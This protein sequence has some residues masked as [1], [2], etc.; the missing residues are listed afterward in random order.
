ML[1][2]AT[3]LILY[4]NYREGSEA[5]CGKQDQ[6]MSTQTNIQCVFHM[7]HEPVNEEVY[8]DITTGNVLRMT[9]QYSVI[10]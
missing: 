4:H 6:K 8:T 7:L 9:L 2:V 5:H 10:L 1:P 3:N